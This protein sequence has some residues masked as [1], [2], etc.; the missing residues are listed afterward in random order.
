M[1]LF[2]VQL[3]HVNYILSREL[4]HFRPYC[5]D[6]ILILFDPQQKPKPVL[7][8]IRPN[9]EWNCVSYFEPSLETVTFFIGKYNKRNTSRV[10]SIS[11]IRRLLWKGCEKLFPNKHLKSKGG[12]MALSF[13]DRQTFL[14]QR[15]L[16]ILRLR[17]IRSLW[18]IQDVS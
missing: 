9:K 13:K 11:F 14:S 15:S 17:I 3:T 4:T 2:L 5:G 6:L 16:V 12:L 10:N 7:V 8:I 1:F 18:L